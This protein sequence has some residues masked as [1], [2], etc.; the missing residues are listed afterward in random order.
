MTLSGLPMRTIIGGMSL[1]AAL[2]DPTTAPLPPESSR[3]CCIIV[4]ERMDTFYSLLRWPIQHWGISTFVANSIISIIGGNIRQAVASQPKR[5]AAR[6]TAFQ[7]E[8]AVRK[9]SWLEDVHFAGNKALLWEAATWAFYALTFI[10][11]L[12]VS[13]LII[14]NEIVIYPLVHV[15]GHP[16]GPTYRVII[17]ILTANA[18][19][20]ILQ[21]AIRHKQNFNDLQFCSSTTL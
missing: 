21:S 6:Y 1:K 13:I 8:G 11:I 9:L 2:H 15:P 20:Y 7:L 14:V 17:K 3:Y 12:C 16:A 4:P 5:L 10:S 19:L 18:G